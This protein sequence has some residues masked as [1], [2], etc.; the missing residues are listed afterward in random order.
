MKLV[1]FDR[2]S[3]LNL[4]Y[5]QYTLDYFLDCM[6]ELGVKNVELLGGHQG[7]WLDP[8]SYQ[9]SRPVCRMLQERGLHCPVFTPQ[10]C[11]FGYQYGVKEP[12][13]IEKTF[14]FFSNGIRLGAELGAKMMEANSGWGYWNEPEEEGLK[15]AADMFSRLSEVAK[16]NDVTIVAESLRPQE[17]KIGY[18]I[19]QMKRLFD[20]VNHPNFKVMIDLT[21]MSVAG[22]SIQDWFDVFGSENI[23]HVHFQDCNPYGHYIWGAGNRSL[24]EDLET[25]NRNGY[26][27]YLTQELTDAA[28]YL[29]PFSYDKQNI[30]NLKMYMEE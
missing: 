18:R 22:E 19:D 24:R 8:E 12:E 1:S 28:Y 10:N 4:H 6:V 2:L 5:F 14:G 16:D 20:M 23:A 3:V 9:D 17:S 25:L 13:L 7:L 11:R 30:R 29:D 27:G 21:A 15:R 26:Q